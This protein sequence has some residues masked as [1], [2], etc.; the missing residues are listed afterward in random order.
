MAELATRAGATIVGLHAHSGS[1]IMTP[2]HWAQLAETLAAAACHFPHVSVL[3]VG[4]GLGVPEKPAQEPLDLE[5][6][7]AGLG[8][9]MESNPG[10]SLWLEPGRFVVA[11]SGV[12]LARVTQIKGKGTV[13]YVGVATGM[14]SLIRPALY[15]SYHE[16]VNLT[17]LGEEPTDRANVV[18]PICETGDIL[19]VDRLLPPTS[20][21]DVLLI[22]N[23]GAYGFV[24]ASW[25]NLREPAPQRYM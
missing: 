24:M 9:V 12:I 10:K 2:E 23:T 21:G 13:R 14:N 25:Y 7:A 16:I 4:G 15:G 22:A 11:E 3:D 5:A 20:E 17:R 1:G 8:H 6:V 19:G 18:G